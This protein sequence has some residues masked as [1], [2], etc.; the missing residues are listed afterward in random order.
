MA[1]AAGAAAGAAAAGAA[2]ASAA[3]AAAGAVAEASAAGGVA[4]AGAAAAESAAGVVAAASS[5]FFWQA[6][7]LSARAPAMATEVMIRSFM[8]LLPWRTMEDYPPTMGD[9]YTA[10]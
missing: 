4:A 2:A 7:R 5:A 8:E 3:G 9:S 1:P 6:D 10:S